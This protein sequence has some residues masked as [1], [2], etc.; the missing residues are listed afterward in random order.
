[1]ICSLPLCMLSCS[2]TI[3]S[4]QYLPVVLYIIMYKMVLTFE[5]VD[6]ILWCNYSNESY[7]AVL[8]C[9]TVYYDVQGDSNFWICGRNALV[10]CVWNE[11]YSVE[12]CMVLFI[13]KN[14]CEVFGFVSCHF[15][16]TASFPRRFFGSR[17]ARCH[18]KDEKLSSSLV[19]ALRLNTSR[20][21]CAAIAV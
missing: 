10:C 7:W 21:P 3:H 16:W 19:P 1:M 15:N 5:S 13:P 9:G 20:D 4:E 2:V 17:G 18:R 8:S 6:E 11:T 12:R 14:L